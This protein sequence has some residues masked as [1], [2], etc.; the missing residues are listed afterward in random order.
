MP[1]KSLPTWLYKAR[2]KA[3]QSKMVG[4]LD[5]YQDGGTTQKY[6]PEHSE[7]F[8]E[9]TYALPE[10]TVTEQKSSL[11]DILS[12]IPDKNLKS[13]Y[14]EDIEFVKT[15]EK[16]KRPSYQV[17]VPGVNPKGAPLES[18]GIFDPIDW[19]TGAVGTK[20][21]T[22]AAKTFLPEGMKMPEV[23]KYNPWAF[24]PNPNAY[25]RM[26]GKEGYKDALESGVIRAKQNAA[27]WEA[28]KLIEGSPNYEKPY[29]SIGKPWDKNLVPGKPH[30]GYKG[31][32]MTEVIPDEISFMKNDINP[33]NNIGTPKSTLYTNNPNLKFYKE[34]WL[35]GY[36]EV[37]KKQKGGSTNWL[38]KY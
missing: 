5:T 20:A 8:Q 32:Y 33:S 31:P 30:M 23:Y 28:G 13:Q 26:I 2:G 25:Y 19:I 7:Y 9:P 15:Q 29:F 12:K 36:K 18:A 11:E 6:L 34:H 3:I 27:H 14:Q 16:A 1:K 24:K 38:D 17:P 22:G 10:F 4:W 37:P 21:L 35:Q